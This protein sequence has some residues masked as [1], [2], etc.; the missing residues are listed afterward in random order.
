MEA[1]PGVIRRRSAPVRR[2]TPDSL[3]WINGWPCWTLCPQ[4]R[5][6]WQACQ[7]G[8]GLPDPLT[9]QN[10]LNRWLL[11]SLGSPDN[12][13]P[14]TPSRPSPDRSPGLGRSA[15]PIWRQA[16]DGL[17]RSLQLVAAPRALDP[18]Q[19]ALERDL[20][21]AMRL[22]RWVGEEE[23]AL[24]EARAAADLGARRQQEQLILRRR[25]LLVLACLAILVPLLWPPVIVGAVWLFPRTFRRLLLGGITLV[26]A[27]VLTVGLLVG[28]ILHRPPAPVAP[29]APPAQPAAPA[30][31]PAVSPSSP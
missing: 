17:G 21:E 13:D 20:E 9:V 7:H 19:Q 29:Q 28:Q 8:S 26:A 12:P 11:R 23:R 24:M 16:L 3:F 31:S 14:V 4:G 22:G 15:A 18:R 10:V 25:I 6:P 1:L 30:V 27:V 5:I 2:L